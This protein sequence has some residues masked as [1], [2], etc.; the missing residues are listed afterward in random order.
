[1]LPCNCTLIGGAG[2]KACQWPLSLCAASL[3]STRWKSTE[4]WP[5]LFSGSVRDRREKRDTRI[6][7]SSSLL[8]QGNDQDQMRDIWRLANDLPS[9]APRVRL[10]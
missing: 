9:V 2:N 6:S 4:Y 3:C 1:M 5:A 10:K 7:V 8:A